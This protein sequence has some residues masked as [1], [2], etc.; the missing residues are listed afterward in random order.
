LNIDS[1]LRPH[2]ALLAMAATAACSAD[3]TASGSN[4]TFHIVAGS[5]LTDTV[6]AEVTQALVVQLN[7]PRADVQIA[8]V[9]PQSDKARLSERGMWICPLSIGNCGTGALSVRTDSAGRASVRLQFGTIA[10]PA[11]IVISAPEL[12]VVDSAQYV[13]RPG[14]SVAFGFAVRD[15]SAYV[16]ASFATGPHLADRFGNATTGNFSVSAVG[17]VATISANGTFTA[18]QI[19]R[20]RAVFH[21]GSLTDT[22]WITVPPRGTLAVYDAGATGPEGI[23]TVNLDGSGLRRRIAAGNPDYGQFVDWLPDGEITYSGVNERLFAVDA[24]GIARRV[25][26]PASP[27]NYEAMGSTGSDGSVVYSA[28]SPGD[29]HASIWRVPSVGA[30]PVRIRPAAQTA[31]TWMAA[32]TPDAHRIAFV[33][34]GGV[35]AA[36][37]TPGATAQ[38]LAADGSMPRWSPTGARIVFNA[39]TTLHV[40][41]ADGSSARGIG[42]QHYYYPRA[43]WSPD[44]LWIIARTRNRLELINATTNEWIPLPPWSYSYLYP[45]WQRP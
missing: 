8:F 21:A 28:W 11:V 45:A 4:S 2:V 37:V 18:R 43:D 7:E 34:S 42:P 33:A 36:D 38:F 23:A 25:S 17:T 26:G 10:G 16:G 39:D 24:A 44:A 20:G 35:F 14:N 40:V 41:N 27:A 19:G 6:E 22:A 15:S 3:L 12:G 9:P 31:N 29:D 1:L 32:L 5:G 13:V 30:T